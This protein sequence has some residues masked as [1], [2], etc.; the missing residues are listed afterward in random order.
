MDTVIVGTPYTDANGDREAYT[1]EL[2][3]GEDLR[4]EVDERGG[5][6]LFLDRRV[7]ARFAAGSWAHVHT[8][9]SGE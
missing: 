9:P 7:L 6:H 2:E 1:F 4:S 8:E 5:L 3:K